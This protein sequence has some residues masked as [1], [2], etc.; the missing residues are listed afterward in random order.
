M[1][2]VWEALYQTLNVSLAAAVLLLVKW[3]LRDKLSPRW[4]YAVWAVLALR[5][6]IPAGVVRGII[7]Q[8]SLWLETARSAAELHLNS[9]YT[10]AFDVIDMES[11]FP[12]I[13]AAP[14]SLTD[15]LFAVY[16]VGVAA[17]LVWY[18]VS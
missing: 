2:N 15:W 6:F 18:A 9:A 10:S 8:L 11:V 12:W 17:T 1:S 7:P 13:D 4:Q 14:V 16:A 3:L 5:A